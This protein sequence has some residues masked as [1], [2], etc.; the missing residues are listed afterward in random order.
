MCNLLKALFLK[1]IQIVL[2]HL[3]TFL[4]SLSFDLARFERPYNTLKLKNNRKEETFFYM[5]TSN[6]FVLSSFSRIELFTQNRFRT[7]N[8][9]INGCPDHGRGGGGNLLN[10]RKFCS[11]CDTHFQKFFE[12]IADSSSPIFL[13]SGY[14]CQYLIGG[15]VRLYSSRSTGSENFK[16][17]D[18]AFAS[19]FKKRVTSQL[20]TREKI[21]QRKIDNKRKRK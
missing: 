15:S 19:N 2:F 17:S 3:L 16:F 14:S 8:L 1:K 18:E 9:N 12:K 11:I 7:A 10:L 13:I 4:D 21:L 20:L 6:F 5:K